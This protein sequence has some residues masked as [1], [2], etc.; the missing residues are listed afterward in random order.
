[1]IQCPRP[2]F[3]F[4]ECNFPS[5][6]MKCIQRCKFTEPTAIQS[7][8]FPIGLSGLNMVGI[9]RTGSG[10]TLAFLL[11]S[12]LHIRAQVNF[13]II[14]DKQPFFLGATSTRRRSNCRCSPANSRARAAGGASLK[15]F[16]RGFGYLHHLRIWWCSK[17]TTDPRS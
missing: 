17:R 2:V 4:E 8:G 11:P 10:K 5:Y 6:I 7:I 9:S 14:S 1:M 12:M 13:L 15:G 16:R 3:K